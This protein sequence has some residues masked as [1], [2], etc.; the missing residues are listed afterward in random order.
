MQQELFNSPNQYFEFIFV[1]LCSVTRAS[2][3]PKNHVIN[4]DGSFEG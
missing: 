1:T 3:N 2:E 4:E